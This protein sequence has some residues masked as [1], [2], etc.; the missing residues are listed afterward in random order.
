MLITLKLVYHIKFILI[1]EQNLG[2]L[3]SQCKTVDDNRL[4]SSAV[5]VPD[6]TVT[7]IMAQAERQQKQVRRKASTILRFQDEEAALS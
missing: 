1:L 4:I 2:F 5:P 7:D 3:K 6:S